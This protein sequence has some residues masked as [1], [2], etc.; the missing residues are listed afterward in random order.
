ME[1]SKEKSSKANLKKIAEYIENNKKIFDNFIEILKKDFSITKID[2][3]TEIIYKNK[4]FIIQ[5]TIPHVNPEDYLKNQ[6]NIHISLYD[7]T[8]TI[9]YAKIGPVYNSVKFKK[10]LVN[11]LLKKIFFIKRNILEKKIDQEFR[12]KIFGDY[13]ILKTYIKEYNKNNTAKIRSISPEY[14]YYQGNEISLVFSNICNDLKI[15]IDF[16]I[17]QLKIKNI[18]ITTNN[19][20]ELENC[21]SKTKKEIWKFLRQL[22]KKLKTV[23]KEIIQKHDFYNKINQL[24]NKYS[25]IYK[26]MKKQL[27]S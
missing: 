19:F 14:R 8:G 1:I 6:N 11:Y 15:E 24:K 10:L 27:I 2:K 21:I 7:K 22:S 25:K 17:K 12:S 20:V 5:T 26:E 9:L 23:R 18:R 16:H 3:D 13:G 4:D